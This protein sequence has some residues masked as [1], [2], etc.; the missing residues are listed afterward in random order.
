MATNSPNLQTEGADAPDGIGNTTGSSDVTN[1]EDSAASAS[2]FSRNDRPQ[3][4]QS[5]RASKGT[6][7]ESMHKGM[8]DGSPGRTAAGAAQGYLHDAKTRASAEAEPGKAYAQAAVNAAG[9]KI[10]DVKGKAAD[11]KERGM[12]FAAEEPMKA[13]AYAAAGSAVVTALLM[14]LVRGRR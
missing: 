1:T 3:S 4:A 14:T 9:K 2:G 6:A 11:L 5:D 8:Q 7:T 10:H 13:V 12:Q